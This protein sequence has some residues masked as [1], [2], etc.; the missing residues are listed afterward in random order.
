M[1]IKINTK[2]RLIQVEGKVNKLDL[3]KITANLELKNYH[4]EMVSVF[5][6]WADPVVYDP[7][8]PPVFNEFK[9]VYNIET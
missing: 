8:H 6:S 3:N 5:R 9:K 7:D 1:K 2:A 4:I